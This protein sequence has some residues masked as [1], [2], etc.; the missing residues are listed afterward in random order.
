MDGGS[1][2]TALHE[3]PSLVVGGHSAGG[4]LACFLWMQGNW[5]REAGCDAAAIRGVLL[6]SPALDWTWLTGAPAW[7]R[8]LARTYVDA[9]FAG[10]SLHDVSPLVLARAAELADVPLLLLGAP[11]EFGW[12]LNQHVAD[13]VICLPSFSARLTQAGVRH[14]LEYTPNGRHIGSLLYAPSWWRTTAHPF[15]NAVVAQRDGK[16][17]APHEYKQA[18]I[19]EPGRGGRRSKSPVLRHRRQ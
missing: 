18:T 12:F 8:T 6:H 11:D 7:V 15:W 9:Q 10:S 19:T 13:H 3:E 16:R 5:L 2:R 4:Q 1:G 14:W 17:S